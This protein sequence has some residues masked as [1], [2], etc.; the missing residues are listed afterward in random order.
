MTSVVLI[1]VVVVVVVVVDASR[2][3]CFSTDEENG[4][5]VIIVVLYNSNSTF[6]AK[7][8]LRPLD[9]PNVTNKDYLG[10]GNRSIVYPYSSQK[11][12]HLHI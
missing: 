6:W 10:L 3:C 1:I 11:V 12:I 8:F 5:F 9:P 7:Y 2:L 4:R